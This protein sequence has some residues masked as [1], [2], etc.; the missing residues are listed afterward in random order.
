M[1][2]F[3]EMRQAIAVA[4]AVR[5]QYRELELLKYGRA[6][7]IND[8]MVGMVGDVG[9]LAQLVGAQQGIRPGP[10]D[11]HS[12]IGHELSDILWS[13]FVLADELGVDVEAAFASTM[14]DLRL[15]VAEKVAR[16]ELER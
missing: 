5:E 9:D 6:W 2:T 4:L 8:L 1:F 7:S 11:L 14:E 13:V 12:A 10:E 3:M 15:R 16:A